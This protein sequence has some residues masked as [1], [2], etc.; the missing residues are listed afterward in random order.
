[1]N[2]LLKTAWT[3]GEKMRMSFLGSLNNVQYT[4][5]HGQLNKAKYFVSAV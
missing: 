1:M 3:L 4:E 5:A 2:A